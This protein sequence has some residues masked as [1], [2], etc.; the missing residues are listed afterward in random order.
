MDDKIF[1]GNGVAL[2]ISL[3]ASLKSQDEKNC[4]LICCEK[5]KYYTMADK[6]ERTGPKPS[7]LL[8]IRNLMLCCLGGTHQ[9][10]LH[11]C[12]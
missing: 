6:F 5:K 4:S 8:R 3:F 9:G 10:L 2:N 7:W 11:Y 12:P 1:A